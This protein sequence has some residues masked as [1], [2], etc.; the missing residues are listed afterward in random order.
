MLKL[1]RLFSII[2]LT[3]IV[4]TTGLL[5]LFYRLATIQ[6]T[7]ELAQANSRAFA[8]TAL[9]SLRPELDDYL[10]T[11][12]GTR[13]HGEAAQ[14]LAT[15]LSEVVEQESTRDSLG[16]VVRVNL[17]DRRG[18]VI[19]ST[20]RDR[21]G[22]H[23][24]NT[25]GFISA[26]NGRVANK[27]IYRDVFNR[28]DGDTKDAHLEANLLESYVPVR[29]GATQSLDAVFESYT[30]VSPLVAQ[31]QNA[32]FIVLAAVA[33][34][35]LL[36]YGVLVL[37]MRRELRQIESQQHLLVQRGLNAI[38]TQQHSISERTAALEMLSAQMLRRDEMSKKKL[39]FGLHEGLAQTLATIKMGIEHRLA[40]AGVRKE[41]HEQLASI[42]S[43]L[44]GAIRNVQA[45]ATGLRPSSLDELG[46]LA[47]ID[48]FC[49]KFEY[50]HPAIGVEEEISV[51][52]EDVPAP[53][54]IVIY[55]IIESALTNVVRY[56]NTDQIEIALHLQEGA[57]TLAIDD[58]S[59]DARYA[60]TT[61]RDADSDLQVS[62]AEARERAILSGGSFSVARGKTGG[63]SLRASWPA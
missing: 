51:S 9:L 46:L 27:L 2:G 23:E 15:R 60:A 18:V 5:T 50:L 20:D 11:A 52:E 63:V 59:Q 25:T 7:L 14:R 53:L 12:P 45:I 13:R 55:R 39:A 19:F 32:A 43:L 21:I 41:E 40:Q 56:E 42:V 16:P 35:L 8:Q 22:R 30:D 1:L 62:F 49:R 47:T 26:I 4:V 10:A 33:L 17:F 57:L 38:E 36:L 28:F 34:G 29:S 37:L 48:W 31:N 44:Q 58:A 61:G 24:P 6:S 3:S 54:K